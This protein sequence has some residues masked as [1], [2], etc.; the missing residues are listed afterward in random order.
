MSSAPTAE[1]PAE[2]A[3]PVGTTDVPRA[4]RPSLGVVVGLYCALIVAA[5][6]AGALFGALPGAVLDAV[7][8]LAL[9]DHFVLGSRFDQGTR[10]FPALAL[11]PLLRLVSLALA[12]RSPI[13]FYCA[14]GAPVLFATVLVA[15]ALGLR[16]ML[17]VRDIRRRSQWPVALAGIPIGAAAAL[18]FHPQ[19]LVHD[20]SWRTVLAGCIVV[21]VFGGVLEELLFRGVVQRS[22]DCFGASAVVVANLLFTSTYLASGSVAV[23]LAAA[24]GGLLA[25]WWARRT[26]IVVGVAAAH[27]LI[28]AGYL[29]L[30]P[31]LL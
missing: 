21:F 28:A 14:A 2:H 3:G 26:G 24:A 27:G 23:V 13:A 20:E 1:L 12:V 18:V 22:L 30:W 8:L 4:L 25:G 31:V 16:S 7:V 17:R 15:R 9:V 29:V 5:E 11:V 6:V 10:L 19:P